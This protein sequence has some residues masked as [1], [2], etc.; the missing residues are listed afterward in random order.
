MF[1]HL[2]SRPAIFRTETPRSV[3]VASVHDARVRL[4]GTTVRHVIGGLENCYLDVIPSQHT[5][6]RVP[7]RR[8]SWW[9]YIVSVRLWQ[10]NMN[11]GSDSYASTAER[12]TPTNRTCSG[13]GACGQLCGGKSVGACGQLCGGKTTN[14]TELCY[15]QL[16][17]RKTMDKTDFLN[18]QLCGG[19]TK[20]YTELTLRAHVRCR[21]QRSPHR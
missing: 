5:S 11:P 2:V 14:D 19:K 20:D 21:H 1:E 10:W 18:G 7:L 15:G 8:W 4:G 6:C 3:I 9:M 12:S 17:R 13:V 16:C